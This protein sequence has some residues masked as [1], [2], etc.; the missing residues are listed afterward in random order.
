MWF[1]FQTQFGAINDEA[2]LNIKNLYLTVSKLLL[3]IIIIFI[4]KKRKLWKKDGKAS[5]LYG[6]LELTRRS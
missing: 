4:E 2:K 6:V 3:I 1:S 5:E